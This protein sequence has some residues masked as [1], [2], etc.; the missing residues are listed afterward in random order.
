MRREPA[1]RLDPQAQSLLREL[2]RALLDALAESGAVTDALRRLS[3]RG[4]TLHLTLDC[5]PDE[6]PV[7][8]I[9]TASPGDEAPAPVFRIDAAD[10]AFLRSIGIDP[11]RRR[12]R[13]PSKAR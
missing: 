9:G 10:L 7:G 3:R 11:T 4:L 5:R 1:P 6:P 13:P 2:S 12:R 8:R